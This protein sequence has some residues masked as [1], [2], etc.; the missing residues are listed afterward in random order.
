V[1]SYDAGPTDTAIL[2]E[3]IGE[4]FERMAAADPGAEALVDVAGGRRWTYGE[5]NAEVDLI[6]R[7]L[8]SRGIEQGKRIGIWAPNCP[9]WTIVQYATAKIGAILVTSNTT[10]LNNLVAYDKQFGLETMCVGGGQGMAMIV[11]RLD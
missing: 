3:T 5:L 6:A 2:E 1:K 8:M 7:G 4:N 10:L 11:E 9:E